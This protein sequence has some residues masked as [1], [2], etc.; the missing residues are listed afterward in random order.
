MIARLLAFAITALLLWAIG[1]HV[2]AVW[3]AL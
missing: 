2:L 3:R 1:S